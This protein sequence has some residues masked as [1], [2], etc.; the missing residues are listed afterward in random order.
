MDWIDYFLHVFMGSPILRS[1]NLVPSGKDVKKSLFV[2]GKKLSQLI[3][4]V[5]CSIKHNDL[6]MRGRSQPVLFLCQDFFV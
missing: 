4:V 5:P 1:G 6:R 2:F 3:K